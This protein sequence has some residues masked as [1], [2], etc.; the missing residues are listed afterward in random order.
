MRIDSQMRIGSAVREEP[1]TDHEESTQDSQFLDSESRLVSAS[2]RC[3][4]SQ[5]TNKHDS[6]KEVNYLYLNKETLKKFVFTVLQ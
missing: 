3:L 1:T 2:T 5:R 4:I 6:G